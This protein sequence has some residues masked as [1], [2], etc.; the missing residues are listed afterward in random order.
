VQQSTICFTGRSRE[1]SLVK[2]Q[3]AESSFMSP[4]KSS[5]AKSGAR[6]APAKATVSG[7][8]RPAVPPPSDE[9]ARKMADAEKLSASIFVAALASH[10]IY[11]RESDPPACRDL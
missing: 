7:Q 4:R 8:S 3:V 11:A 10:R 9:L 5:P 6:K 2:S 1:T